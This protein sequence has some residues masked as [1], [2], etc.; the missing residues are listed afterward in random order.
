MTGLWRLVGPVVL[1]AGSFLSAAPAQASGPSAD[2]TCGYATLLPGGSLTGD[3]GLG[4]GCVAAPGWP[5][6][7]SIGGG[8]TMSYAAIGY[9]IYCQTGTVQSIA[10]PLWV[11]GQ[12][13]VQ[14]Q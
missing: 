10:D 5:T 2:Y 12:H 1:I 6:S 3:F 4:T 13:C 7:G 9:T 14:Q 11:N 8:F